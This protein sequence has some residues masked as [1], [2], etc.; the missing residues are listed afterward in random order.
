MSVTKND[1][2]VV[3][4]TLNEEKAIGQIICELRQ[5]GYHN[6]LIIDGY[7]TDG[8][9]K[10]AEANGGHV[11]F[12]HSMGKSGA[13]E[14]A[15][16]YVKTPYFIVM[17][18]DCTYDPKDIDNFLTHAE[19]YD[20]IIGVRA[21]GRKHIPRMNRVGNW[22]I[23][24]T[25]NVLFGTKLSDVCSG[26]YLIKTDMARH[27]LL[28]TKGFDV[29]VE[30]AAQTAMRGKVT[31]VPIAYRERVGLQKL[32][33]W[34][35]GIQIFA[36]IWNLART[37]NPIFLFSFFSALIMI[38]ALAILSWVF[39]DWLIWGAWHTGWAILGTILI[40]VAVQIFTISTVAVLL[41]RM[42]Q[43]VVKRL[44]ASMPSD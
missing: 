15:I 31:E 43:R 16:E 33:S 6:I 42:E 39:A 26:M 23:T 22:M 24:K 35:H 36:T 44:E 14:T 21:N 30:I 25:F 29:E 4:P 32:N 8:T 37:H 13:I 20:Q 18:G 27:L 19:R 10:I 17:D 28:N 9:S 5:I 3:L 7:S 40:L 2:T 34:R 1:V 12:Q 41:K 11:V 38:P